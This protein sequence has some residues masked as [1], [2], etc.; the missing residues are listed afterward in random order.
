M[1]F[2]KLR[3]LKG[4]KSV[5][6]RKLPQINHLVNKMK[7]KGNTRSKIIQNFNL[8]IVKRNNIQK[9]IKKETKTTLHRKSTGV[10]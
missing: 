3:D 6:S 4:K 1:N 10:L 5:K 7:I 9:D 8:R 2:E